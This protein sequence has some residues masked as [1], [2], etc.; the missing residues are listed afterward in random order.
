MSWRGGQREQH[1]TVTERPVRGRCEDRGRGSDG[2]PSRDCIL[3]P[4]S[5][6]IAEEPTRRR[7]GPSRRDACRTHRPTK[8]AE[9][10]RAAVILGA[11]RG[12]SLR[13][14]AADH[15]VSYET[16]RRVLRDAEATVA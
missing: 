2:L 1:T 8:L 9:V 5:V 6:P 4:G 14:L 10:E 16:V 12:R 11:A 7:T 15:G 3:P 13:S